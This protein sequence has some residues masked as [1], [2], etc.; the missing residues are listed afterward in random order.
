MSGAAPRKNRFRM[1][2]GVVAL[3]AALGL[4]GCES[5]FGSDAPDL[6][7]DAANY[8]E[9]A[10]EKIYADAWAQI[11]KENW[12]AAAKQFDEVERQHPYSPWARRAS[13]MSAYCYYMA[14]KYPDAISTADNYISL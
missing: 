12:E 7:K 10:V 6:N 9:R 13:L 5:L 14:N 2:A 11:D 8:S 3:A 1:L 4:S